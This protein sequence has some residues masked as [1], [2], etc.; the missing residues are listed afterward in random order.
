MQLKNVVIIQ[1]LGNGY[2]QAVW[3]FERKGVQMV[4]IFPKGIASTTWHNVEIL[5]SHGYS[6][7]PRELLEK[8]RFESNVAR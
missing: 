3:Q 8:L 2:Y 6:V 7:E 5:I 4:H 1:E